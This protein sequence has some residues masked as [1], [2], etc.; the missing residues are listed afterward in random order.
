MNTNNLESF[1]QAARI[2]IIDLVSRKLDF[3]L[4]N[5]SQSFIDTYASQLSS[6][7]DKIKQTSRDQ[8]IETVA[9]T[10][11]N[12]FMALRFMDA[13]GYTL[14]KVIT[15]LP[16]MSN[17]EI[18]QNALA[19]HIE[20]DMH[21]DRQRLNDLLDGRTAT[22]DAHTEAYKMLIVAACNQW[23]TAMP[24]MFERIS[25]YTELLLPDDLLSDY[26]IVAD[27]RNGMTDED[28][29][30][31]EI[32]GW[33]YQF[34]ISAENARLIKSKKAYAKH[35]LA[36]ASQLF[37]PKWIVK[38][39]VD[40]TLGQ[41]WSE[42]NPSTSMLRQL[43][44]YI[45][46]AY[47][48]QLAP[49]TK[50]RL[51]EIKFFDPCVGS[52]HILVY[53]F[54]VFYLMYEEQGYNTSEIPELII[55]HNLF[56]TDIDERA[57]QIAAFVLTMK[58]RRKNSRF[59]KQNITPNVTFY[60]DFEEDAK[61][62]NAK[63]IGSLINVSP[64][65]MNAFK[66]ETG[67]IYAEQQQKLKQLYT[68]LGQRYDCVVT[69]PPYISSD[70]ME[71]SV[72]QFL[73]VNYSFCKSDLFAAF[74]VRCLNITEKDGF[75]GYICP[76]V[77][78]FN[79][80]YERMRENVISNATINNLIQLEYNAFEPAV[81]PICTFTLRN[82][83]LDVEG[84]Y[85]KLS[86][87]KGHWNQ[88]K[89]TLEAIINP[90]VNFRFKA[91]QKD[92]KKIDGSPISYWA[93]NTV[94]DI[95]KN[96]NCIEDIAD[97]RQGMKTSDNGRFLR[98]WH[99]IAFH[100][101]GFNF[102]N[103]LLAK[104]SGLKWF[105]YDK[106]GSFRKWYGNNFHV[107]N[108]ENDGQEIMQ[109]AT[110]LYKTPTRTITAMNYYFREGLTWSALSSGTFS[111]RYTD[112]G[113]LFD[114]KGSKL[115]L[116]TE[117]E[118]LTLAVLGFM[119]SSLVNY[120]LGV[121]SPSLDYNAGPIKKLP[122]NEQ[123][124][125]SNLLNDINNL[126][127]RCIGIS[128]KDW[129]SREMS[130]DFKCNELLIHN[131]SSI[132]KTLAIYK[133]DCSINFF[134]LHRCE[135][136]IN[137][138]F[139]DLY[140]LK[141][142]LDPYIP[143]GDITILQEEL[144][145]RKLKKRRNDDEDIDDEENWSQEW[146]LL[147]YNLNN[148]GCENLSLPFDDSNIMLQLISYAVGCMFGRYSLDKPGLILANQGDTIEDYNRIIGEGALTPPSG[149][150]GAPDADNIIP[151]LDGE[152]FTDDIVGRFREFIKV[153]FS[154]DQLNENIGFIEDNIPAKDIRK[155]FVKDFYNDHIKRYK[156]R[157]IYWM[158]SSPKGHF[159]ALI[160]MH[161]YQ[162]DTCSK[163]LNDY[164]QAFIVKLDAARH[165][166][167]MFSL[168]DDISAREKILVNKEIDKLDTMIKD[169]REYEKTLFNIAI[170]RIN[171][172]LDDGVKVNYQKFKDVLLPIKGLEKEEE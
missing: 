91:N 129:N 12:R 93:N 156:K 54:D 14:P 140:N 147:E 13:N 64:E 21:L 126:V 6:L 47:K 44:F 50:K 166:Q 164:L 142:E 74:I 162:P 15:P 48:N 136:E 149:G 153:A 30:Q 167:T 139:I 110:E 27:I 121:T 49:R 57:A 84:D 172:D 55:K 123:I 82:G 40:N 87:F 148:Y 53:A 115:F 111:M 135:V 105:P 66:V 60:Q 131:E 119:N 98:I 117:N 36:P 128:K 171:I 31:E 37:T 130:W 144:L 81:V 68:F 59:L 138:I 79:K 4:N 1:A 72:K 102:K 160:Y 32:L 71:V 168:K 114:A 67:S 85:I 145:T 158:F 159:K 125:K 2:K 39:M 18:L 165:T 51:E 118:I 26:S 108:W 75:I 127:D 143:L 45:T 33:L 3:V 120:L 38:Y 61:F 69:N 152:W 86:E 150:W 163:L 116:K 16:G 146:I 23:Y 19:G 52:G 41:L 70:R 25:D 76:F 5:T 170:Q 46:P 62:S 124:I 104:H 161:R 151:V 101:I 22:P 109:F 90:N 29:Q 107:I 9:Y 169:C 103:R 154:A 137:K 113:F 63:A 94:R 8:V 96:S 43:E 80:F 157:P 141:N 11:F 42:M 83:L 112:V 99:E 73:E 35:E 133:K 122:F 88:P 97:P 34:Y 17:P 132:K 77:W 10:W 100:K 95:F 7:N 155:Y 56:G 89:K 24:F 92:F 134:D 28:C 65:E 78:M 58:G 106:G 20:A